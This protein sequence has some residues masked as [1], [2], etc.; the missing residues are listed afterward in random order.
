MFH[1][2]LYQPEI[3]HNTGAVGRTCVALG[4]KLW[5]VRPFGFQIEDRHLKRCGLDYW[6]HLD[7]EAVDDWSMLERRLGTPDRR[8]YW[9]LSK[10]ATKT[11]AEVEYR[12]EHVFVFGNESLGLPSTL[13][14]QYPDHCLR[15]PIHPDARSLNLSVCVGITLFEARRQC[16][17]TDVKTTD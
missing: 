3:P 12:K 5:L 13:L 8:C 4:A 6:P 11:Y 15:V 10:K 1:V 9:F 16:E 7:W 2:V 17:S 14:E